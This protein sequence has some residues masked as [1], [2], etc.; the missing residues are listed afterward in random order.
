MFGKG[1]ADYVSDLHLEVSAANAEIARLRTALASL[2]VE[3]V[4]GRKEGHIDSFPAT[5]RKV[6][7]DA[8]A[9]LNNEQ[10]PSGK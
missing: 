6:V 9:A 5:A 7:A 8:R 2:L 4:A 3:F 1:M 10:T